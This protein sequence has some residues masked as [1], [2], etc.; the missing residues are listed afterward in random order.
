LGRN[1]R[2]VEFSP[3]VLNYE[4]VRMAIAIF[5]CKRFSYVKDSLRQ[6]VL[7]EK[8]IKGEIELWEVIL[9]G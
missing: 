2:L 3:Q 8:E 7:K 4:A 5:F 6:K 1:P 9:I